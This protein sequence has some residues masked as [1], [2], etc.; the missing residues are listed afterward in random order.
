MHNISSIHEHIKR[1]VL[2]V[3]DEFINQQILGNIISEKYEPLYAGNGVEALDVLENNDNISL[4]LLD[5]NM[6]VMDGFTFLEKMKE[7]PSI[8]HIPVIVLT[9]EKEAEI[10]SLRLGAQDFIM[11]PYDM[12][13]IILARVERSI[14]LKEDTDMIAKTARDPLTHLFTLTYFYEYKSWP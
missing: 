2:I 3:E 13:G 14:L 10:Q 7:I 4:I 11:K 8:S 6:P 9:S 12:P 1:R 5:L